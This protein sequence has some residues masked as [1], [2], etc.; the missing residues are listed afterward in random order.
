VTYI[1][2]GMLWYLSLSIFC[3]FICYLNFTCA[4]LWNRLKQYERTMEKKYV[5][6]VFKK[7]VVSFLINLQWTFVNKHLWYQKIYNIKGRILTLTVISNKNTVGVSWA[8]F[9]CFFLLF[10]IYMWILRNILKRR[11]ENDEKIYFNLD[12]IL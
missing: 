4:L 9:I 10:K 1:F 12:Y 2:L 5:Y 6:T 3:F 8:R 11:L 7:S